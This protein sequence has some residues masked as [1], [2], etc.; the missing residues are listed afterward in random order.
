MEIVDDDDVKFLMVVARGSQGYTKLFVTESQI[1]GRANQQ[2]EDVHD[3]ERSNQPTDEWAHPQSFQEF[4]G[5]YGV[6]D[7]NDENMD[8]DYD[9]EGNEEEEVE[10]EEEEDDDD[11]DEEF[12]GFGDDINGVPSQDAG[13]S[14][15]H[16][17]YNEAECSTR[18][19]G[20]MNIGA[21]SSNI[22]NPNPFQWVP[23]PAVDVENTGI[24]N[25]ATQRGNRLQ[26]MGFYNSKAELRALFRTYALETGIQW[27]V[28]HSDNIRYELKCVHPQCKWRARATREQDG[29]Y[30]VLRRMD[31][32]HT[33]P[34][35]QILPHHRQA[36]AESLGNI[37]KSMFVVDRIY[38]PKEIISDMADRY[39]IDISYTQA[40]R[41]KTYAINALR[42]SPEES[43][44]ILREY[45]H[46][47]E[48]KNPGTMARIDVDLENRFKFFFMCMGCSIRG[49][50]QFCRP[51]ICIDA[52]HLKG[53]YLGSLFIA[54]AK[55]GN[56]QIYPLAFGI[57]HKEGLD[58]W[59]PFLTYLR[60][61][62]GDLPDLAIISDRHHSI[63]AAVA[64]VMPHARHGF[65]NFHIKGN[66]RSQFK[67]TKHIEG[68][69]WRAAKAYRLTDFQAAMNRIA[70]VNPAAATY[71]T[72]IGYDRWARAHF[73][74]WR[75]NIMTTNIAESFNA[76]TRT[77]RALPI[78]ILVEFL[79]STLQH[80][81]FNRR[82][83]AGQRS[84]PLTPWAEDKL[85]RHVFKSANMIVKP[86]NMQQYE[87]H[88]SRQQVFIV[89]LLYRTCD[90]GKFQRSQIPCAHAAAIA[91]YN[92]L[93]DC[94]G[95]VST[96]Y[97]TE[98]LR[99]V[100]EEDI[101]P[102]GDQSTWAPSNL[103]VIFPPV[104]EQR[105]SGRPSSHAR[106]PSQGEEVRQQY[107][108]RCHQPGHTRLR[109]PSPA[110][111]PVVSSYRTPSNTRT[112]GRRTDG[113]THTVD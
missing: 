77:A 69:F 7:D 74:G 113:A 8:E 102:L 106:R 32:T 33:C 42:G 86:I 61:C 94:V 14:Q 28:G 104:M 4:G 75:Y 56:N 72:D 25:R 40:W 19:H 78:T 81:F 49:F 107:C 91:R 103:P 112:R 63:I 109:C 67:N 1:D 18:R 3:E 96:Y 45:C 84:H 60:M 9:V 57:G 110:P 23:E 41:A 36:G 95:W 38:R 34:R 27:K 6:N 20:F 31:E 98:Y 24:T 22:H 52:S 55:D 108:S 66:M 97:S 53:K 58:T 48:L 105:R 93:S 21:Y 30:W 39:R 92:N 62:I 15:S 73:G 99:R 44:G 17:C 51:V 2:G 50:Q 68:L 5:N 83:M 82:N 65:C 43:F 26:I 29:D 79:R 37:L 111:M 13:R 87:V 89:N 12:S 80:W 47:L 59:T 54:V 10:E 64:N 76:L 100:Y 46:N 101:N 90:C 35:D 11:E 88:D 70:R 71:L 16:P 85:A